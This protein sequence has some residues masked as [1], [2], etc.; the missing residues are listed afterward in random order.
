VEAESYAAMKGV[1]TESC[2]DTGGGLNVAS[3]DARDYMDYSINIPS[4]GSYK[5]DFR[6]ASTV[7][8]GKLE[9]RKGSTILAVVTVPNTGGV[10]SW[11]TVSATATLSAGTQT[12]RVFGK[13][14]TFKLN[15]FEFSPASS[16]AA[17]SAP[18]LITFQSRVTVYPNP[19]KDHVIVSSDEM[20]REIEII[21]PSGGSRRIQV[22]THQVELST[23][24]WN[25]G[26][27]LLK[28]RTDK[29][30]TTRKVIIE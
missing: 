1:T 21:T 15:W 23:R 25:R 20:I 22:D 26:L 18:E 30:T 2:T 5:L 12:F 6:V 8:T 29:T 13:S 28:V 3:I 9:F 14:G 19:A 10:Q 4:A 16:A 11:Q 24:D 7:S 17:V 27:Q